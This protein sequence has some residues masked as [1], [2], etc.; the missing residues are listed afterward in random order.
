MEQR[1]K[2]PHK[3]GNLGALSDLKAGDVGLHLVAAVDV[4][5][6]LEKAIRGLM[7]G[8]TDE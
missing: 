3:F 8:K 7:L 4:S 5:D 2:F 6:V 1:V